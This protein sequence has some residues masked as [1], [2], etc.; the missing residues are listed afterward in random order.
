[1]T[2]TT[3]RR[4]PSARTQLHVFESSSPVGTGAGTVVVPAA[5][6]DVGGGTAAVVVVVAASVVLVAGRVVVVRG[7]RVVVVRGGSVVVACV[8]AGAVVVGAVVE[9]RGG[10]VV[11]GGSVE[12][13]G[14]CSVD[15]GTVVVREV[16]GRVASEPESEQLLTAT[17][18]SA[19]APTRNHRRARTWSS[20]RDR[21]FAT[22]PTQGERPEE[23][24]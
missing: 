22:S 5:T 17:R 14:D 10:R 24:R 23:D 18:A 7:G 2:T 21:G 15:E 9:D 20:W 12:P 6:W 1:M 4:N 3:I 13:V 19:A 11:R 16:D 8:V